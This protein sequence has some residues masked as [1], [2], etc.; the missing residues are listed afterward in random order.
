MTR[1]KSAAITL[2]GLA[3]GGLSA[4]GESKDQ[5]SSAWSKSCTELAREIGKREQRRDS[6][7]IDG[8]INIAES[9]F[10]EDSN[11]A[12]AAD[13]E[14]AANAFD[15]ADA[16]KSFDQLTKIYRSKGCR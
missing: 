13:I 11:A 10:A 15:E 4:C 8:W 3:L 7:K 9:A 2:L 16:E 12:A 6:A 5:L 1:I 14:Y